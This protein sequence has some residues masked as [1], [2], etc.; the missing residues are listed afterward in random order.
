MIA[1]GRLRRHRGVALLATIVLAMMFSAALLLGRLGASAGDDRGV[2]R[3]T[4]DALAQAKAA[5]IQYALNDA[6]RPGELPCPDLNR[7]GKLELTID[8]FG[9]NNVP[10]AVLRGWLPHT[11][12]RLA[13]LRDESGARLWYALSETYHAGHRAVLNSET[14]GELRV[15]AANDIVAVVVAPMS[16]VDFVQAGE[17][18]QDPS[19]HDARTDVAAYLEG[20]NGDG[21]LDRYAARIAR[22]PAINDQI[23]TITRAELMS[24]VEK[25]VLAVVVDALTSYYLE[26]GAF[27]W[28]SPLS[29]PRGS[30][31]KGVPGS[32]RGHLPLH[33]LG[34]RF[35]TIDL[36]AEWDLT[37]AD[38]TAQGSLSASD[39][40]SGE[41]AF[42]E[43]PGASGL[44]ECT[45]STSDQ[46]DCIGRRFVTGICNGSPGTRIERI[47][48]FAFTGTDVDVQLPD[49]SRTRRRTVRVNSPAH[50]GPV[51]AGVRL[52]V[53]DTA[54]DGP[55]SGNTCGQ[56][57]LTTDADT[58]G[59]V[60]LGGIRWE[61]GVGEELPRWFTDERWHHLIQAAYAQP[62][63]PPG[64]PTPCSPGGTCLVLEGLSPSDDKAGIVV[65]AGGPLSSQSRLQWA[66]AHY[67]EGHN[68]SS[69]GDVFSFGPSS[70]TFN[71][72]ARVVDVGG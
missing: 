14:A 50:P 26:A 7:D 36:S 39:L 68:A 17:R 72:Q 21:D 52:D 18:P 28:L 34:E 51:A 23:V 57:T 46:V 53:L 42:T 71:D 10:C 9:G 58:W 59:H 5:L 6:N 37:S 3:R 54:V 4:L 38:V 66:P 61:L 45:F 47:Y 69:G 29:D 44:P 13:P 1:L 8:F 63:Q 70:A 65:I 43:G 49:A 31:F 62:M 30:D 24:L 35:E 15:G 2:D 11:T 67:F 64:P 32:R 41:R 40:S 48:R 12:L 33:V 16:P 60:G 56:G 27:P 25:R 22:A 19:L 20:P 55:E